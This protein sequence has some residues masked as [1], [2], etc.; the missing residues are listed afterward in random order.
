MSKGKPRPRRYQPSALNGTF[1]RRPQPRIQIDR[2]L[3]WYCLWTAPRAEGE[4]AQALRKAGLDVYVPVEALA[5][6]RRGKLVEVERPLLSRYMFVGL[7]GARPEWDAVHRA[8]DGP[9]GWVF[10]LP[11]L[12]RVLKSA[13]QT[14]LRV[15]ASA[16]QSLANGL[17]GTASGRLPRFR[18]G[19][20]IRV[21]DGLWRGL[22]A[23]ILD[24]TDLQVRGLLNLFGRKTLVAFAPGQLRAA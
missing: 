17:E 14:P 13:E 11:V 15:P 19:D 12:G 3:A 8:L 18:A 2:G 6:A 5:I 10:G 4:V 16:L 9:H 24:S 1:I 22:Q 21:V 23:E 20:S 7:N